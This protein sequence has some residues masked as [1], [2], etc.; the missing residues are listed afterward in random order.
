[1]FSA[2]VVELGLGSAGFWNALCLGQCP[3][4]LT[5][6]RNRQG[7]RCWLAV[8]L[9]R[10]VA[11]IIFPFQ[12]PGST[13]QLRLEPNR[14]WFEFQVQLL[15]TEMFEAKILVPKTEIL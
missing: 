8:L 3:L 7:S 11:G 12:I 14:P 5:K 2:I 1:M 10:W 15:E 9:G 4:G 13:G 6:W